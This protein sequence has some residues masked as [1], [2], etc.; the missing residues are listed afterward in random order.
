MLQWIRQTCDLETYV[1]N[2]C[3]RI[4]NVWCV[5][6]CIQSGWQDV[7]IQ[8]VTKWL[9][10]CVLWRPPTQVGGHSLWTCMIWCCTYLCVSPVSYNVCVQTGIKQFNPLWTDHPVTCCVVT[11]TLCEHT[12]T[13][14]SLTLRDECGILFLFCILSVQ[15]CSLGIF[16]SVSVSAVVDFTLRLELGRQNQSDSALFFFHV[17]VAILFFFSFFFFKSWTRQQSKL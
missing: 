12:L 2:W 13:W 4:L 5:L 3:K 10:A 14:G 7:K 8:E 17:F 9:T 6:R 15:F 16:V 1:L 11:N